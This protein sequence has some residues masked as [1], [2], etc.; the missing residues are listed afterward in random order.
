MTT[1]IVPRVSGGE[2]EHG[3]LEEFRTDPIGL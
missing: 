3:H 2:E 1:A